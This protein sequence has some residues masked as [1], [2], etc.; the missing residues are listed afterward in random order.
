MDSSINNFCNK[1]QTKIIISSR[2]YLR[3]SYTV[4]NIGIFASY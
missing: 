4:E 1:S 2:G 3:A